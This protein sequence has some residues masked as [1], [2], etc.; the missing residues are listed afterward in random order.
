MAKGSCPAASSARRSRVAIAA[1]GRPLAANR[2]LPAW[3]RASAARA[4]IIGC[5][6]GGRGAGRAF[7]RR[8]AE[9]EIR[10]APADEARHDERGGDDEQDDRERAAD[11]SQQVETGDGDGDQDAQDAVHGAHVLLHDDPPMAREARLAQ[12]FRKWDTSNASPV[13][14]ARQS[15]QAATSFATSLAFTKLHAAATPARPR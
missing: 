15:R 14:T 13:N 3:S 7:P 6:G 9:G 10:R 1:E 12:G 5:S 11:L 4:S 8:Q 2:A